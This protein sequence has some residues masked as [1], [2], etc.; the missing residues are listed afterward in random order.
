MTSM[1]KAALAG[2]V[3]ERC[4]ITKALATRVVEGVVD[5]IIAALGDGRVVRLAGLGSLRVKETAP[6]TV[7]SSLTGG[8]EVHVPANRKIQFRAKRGVI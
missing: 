4:R 6:R 5:E 7:C 2:A 3:A 8:A 1:N